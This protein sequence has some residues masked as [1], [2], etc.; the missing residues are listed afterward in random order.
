VEI[1]VDDSRSQNDP[2]VI[3]SGTDDD[4]RPFPIVSS[5]PVP[6]FVRDSVAQITGAYSIKTA[7]PASRKLNLRLTRFFVNESNKAL[8]S[9]YMAEVHIAY[10][11]LD[12]QGKVLSE[13]ASSGSVTPGAA[14][15]SAAP[16]KESIEERL[17]T[18]NDLLKKGLIT[19]EE[20]KVKRAE[21]LKDA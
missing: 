6:Q 17:R 16:V 19:Q 4:D 9:T 12:S 7:A 11:L 20:Y 1:S 8:G 2:K 15:P 14:A 10:S 21:I 5:V 3:G 18:L 13:S